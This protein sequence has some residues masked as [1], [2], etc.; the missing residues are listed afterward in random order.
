MAVRR[1]NDD[2]EREIAQGA[3]FEPSDDPMADKAVFMRH[4]ARVIGHQTQEYRQ[5]LKRE[6][7]DPAGAK[8]EADRLFGERMREVGQNYDDVRTRE[9]DDPVRSHPAVDWS[10]LDDDGTPAR[11]P[12]ARE[13]GLDHDGAEP[14]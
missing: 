10:Q 11:A 5:G 8:R 3:D 13:R 7:D 14:A 1:H 9:R 4:A 2:A 12:A 6:F